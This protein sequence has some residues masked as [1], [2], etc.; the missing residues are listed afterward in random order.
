VFQVPALSMK[1][2]RTGT[3]RD[4]STD[5]PQPVGAASR[6]DVLGATPER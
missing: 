4:R 6:G 5:Q 3:I 2:L 1:T